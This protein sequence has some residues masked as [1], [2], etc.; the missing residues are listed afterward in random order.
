MSVQDISTVQAVAKLASA[1]LTAIVALVILCNDPA[2]LAKLIR[3][4]P[5]RRRKKRRRQ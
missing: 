1:M 2:L 3:G 4:K 5:R